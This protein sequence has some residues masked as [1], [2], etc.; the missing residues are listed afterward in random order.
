M[1]AKTTNS[2]VLARHGHGFFHARLSLCARRRS[3]LIRPRKNIRAGVFIA[4]ITDAR[5]RVERDI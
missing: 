1:I 4:S 2:P 3:L 5:Y